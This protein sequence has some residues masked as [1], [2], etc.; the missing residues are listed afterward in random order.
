[1]ATLKSSIKNLSK[2]SEDLI[3]E[4]IN[5]FMIKQSEKFALFLGLLS[6]VFIL[7]LLGLVIIIFLSFALA[8]YLNHLLASDYLGYLIVSGI[9]FL[10]FVIIILRIKISKKPLLL[11]VFI[12]FILSIFSLNISYS[13]NY[14]GLN[15]EIERIKHE[16]D[17]NKIKI[18]ADTQIIKYLI[19]ESFIK[20]FFGLFKSKT[21]KTVTDETSEEPKLDEP[22]S[23]KIKTDKKQS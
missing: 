2:E 7:G 20:E 17:K 11:N 6:S 16:I 22:N 21:K 8:S 15:S 23:K 13:K 10:V 3:R 9:F 4:Y 18:K 19:L 14:D 5:L 12:R 1:M